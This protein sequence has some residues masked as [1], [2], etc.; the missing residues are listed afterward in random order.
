MTKPIIGITMGDP[1]GIGPEV[2]VKSLTD[3]QLFE[4]AR[5]LLI[6]DAGVVRQAL[7]LSGLQAQINRVERPADGRYQPGTID[8]VDLANVPPGE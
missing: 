1:A 5:P 7:E 3:A 4:T 8:L 6:G 2:V